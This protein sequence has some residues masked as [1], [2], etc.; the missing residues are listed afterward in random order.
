MFVIAAAGLRLG[1]FHGVT[2]PY[3]G[4]DILK[5]VHKRNQSRVVDVDAV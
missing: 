1:G 4:E 5:L 2:H 3:G